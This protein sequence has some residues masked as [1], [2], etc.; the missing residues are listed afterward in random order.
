MAGIVKSRPLLTPAIPRK[1]DVIVLLSS[2]QIER[3]LAHA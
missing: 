2:G 1:A 3:Q